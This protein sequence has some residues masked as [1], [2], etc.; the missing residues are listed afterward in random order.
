MK[1]G[2][3]MDNILYLQSLGPFGLDGEID[4]ENRVISGFAVISIGETADDRFFIDKEFLNQIVEAGNKA[5]LKSRFGHPSMF[6][7]ALGKL[8]GSATNF[9]FK[10][11]KVLAD[12]KFSKSSQDTP[13]GNLS[14]HVMDLADESPEFLGTSIAFSRD[15]ALEDDFLSKHRDKDGEFKSPDPLNTKNFTHVRLKTLRAVDFVDEPAANPAGLF[16]AY[17]QEDENHLKELIKKH[18]E[19]SSKLS[20]LLQKKKE[21]ESPMSEETIVSDEQLEKIKSDARKE[22]QDRVKSIMSAFPDDPEFA[23]KQVLD[24]KSVLEAKA[25]YSEFLQAK[26]K[27]MKEKADLDA[28][29]KEKDADGQDAV[30]FSSGDHDGKDKKKKDFMQL[31]KGYAKENKCGITEAMQAIVLENPKIHQSF[32]ESC[33]LAKD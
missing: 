9:R 10:D 15:I 31:A 23:S 1:A 17:G 29:D 21:K 3:L 32:L 7:D 33:P 22:E 27:K 5:P 18:E 12:I 8:L 13:S 11:D 30:D 25:E 24:G 2:K 4:R 14:K 26:I 16:S 19:Y 28:K 20:D 6:G